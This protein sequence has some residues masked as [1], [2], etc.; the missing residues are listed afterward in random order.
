MLRVCCRLAEEDR[1]GA[2]LHV[3]AATSDGFAIGFH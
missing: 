2:V 1:S 3:V